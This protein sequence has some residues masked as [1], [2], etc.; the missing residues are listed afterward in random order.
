MNVEKYVKLLSDV[1]MEMF[2]ATGSMF[3]QNYLRSI[4]MFAATG[5]SG[6]GGVSHRFPKGIMEHKVI[7][8]LRAV[9]GDKSLLRQWLRKFIIAL[10]QVGGSH[11]EIVRRL[12]TEMV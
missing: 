12:V 7:Q 8:N 10:G 9:S 1:C 6:P 2:R 3:E 4:N 11:E 5:G